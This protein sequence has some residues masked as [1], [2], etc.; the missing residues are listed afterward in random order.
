V[1]SH[2]AA[3][4]W[5]AYNRLWARIVNMMTRAHVPVLLSAP[6]TPS[7]WNRAVDEVGARLSTTFL[8]LDCADDL[9]AR[10]LSERGWS[11]TKVDCAIADASDLRELG[12]QVLDTTKRSVGDVG[13]ELISLVLPRR[14]RTAV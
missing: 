3:G 8:L 10:R 11:A 9:R 13:A 5:P 4:Q 14:G 1:A 6:V 2:D 7:E 12:L